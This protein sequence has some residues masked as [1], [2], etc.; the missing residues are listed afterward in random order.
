MSDQFDE[1]QKPRRMVLVPADVAADVGA[2]ARWAVE[3]HDAV[4]HYGKCDVCDLVQ[5]Y[6]GK[7]RGPEPM[8][9]FGTK[10]RNPGCGQEEK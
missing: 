9:V 5:R 2:L 6:R 3:A 10:R 4:T 8:D 1:M 7:L